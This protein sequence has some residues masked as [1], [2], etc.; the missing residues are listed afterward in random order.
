MRRISTLSGLTA[1]S[2]ATLLLLA[3]GGSGGYGGGGG[4]TGSGGGG[5]GIATSISISPATA[6]IAMSGTQQYSAVTEDSNGNKISGV[7]LT[8]TS[9]DPA[10]ATVDSN[11]MANA[12]GTGTSAITASVT[13]TSGGVYTTGNGITYTSNK[14]TLAVTTMDAVM[15]TVATG[16]AMAGALV[17]MKD[18]TGKSAVAES[19]DQGRFSLST[20]GLKGPFL[21]KADDG[22]GR[23]LF[24]TAAGSGGANV[25]TVTDLMVRTWYMAHGSTPEAAFADMSAHPAPDAKSLAILDKNFAGLLDKALTAEGLDSQKFSL[26]STSFNTDSKGFDA[27]LDHLS[28]ATGVQLQLQDGLAGRMTEIG[29]SGKTVSF[30]THDM[31]DATT[32]TQH[33]DLPQ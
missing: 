33:F 19:S 8:W 20:A 9:S 12:V 31:G 21:I 23:V 25:D 4:S 30:N 10:V 6:S 26:A 5:S 24:G 1:V 17:T 16:H 27:V 3:C 7:I 13:Y 11:G 29:F 22:R 14:A 32:Q 18:A 28:A 2:L 15:G